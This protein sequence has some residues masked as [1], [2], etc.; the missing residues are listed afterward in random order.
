MFA[1]LLHVV[2]TQRP[3]LCNVKNEEKGAVGL[4]GTSVENSFLH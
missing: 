4:L 3:Y 2:F 1:T